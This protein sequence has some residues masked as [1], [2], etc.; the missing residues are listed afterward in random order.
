MKLTVITKY[1]KPDKILIDD[2]EYCLTL[3]KYK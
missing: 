3:A 2:K 1:F